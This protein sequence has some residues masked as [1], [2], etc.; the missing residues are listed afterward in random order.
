MAE[1]RDPSS[2]VARIRLER[3]T[4]G[5]PVWRGHVRHIQSDEEAYFQDL[6]ALND[7][8]ARVSGVTGPTLTAQPLE[9]AT[10]SEPGTVTDMKRKG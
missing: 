2:F 6:G 8:L 9:D 1:Q 4:N 7:F 3:K 10:K 5:G